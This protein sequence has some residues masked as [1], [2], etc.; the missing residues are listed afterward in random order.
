MYV[1]TISIVR[2]NNIPS[3]FFNIEPDFRWAYAVSSDRHLLERF[4][5][6]IQSFTDPSYL[7]WMPIEIIEWNNLNPNEIESNNLNSLFQID[8]F[9][10][11]G[12]VNGDRTDKY[13]IEEFLPHHWISSFDSEYPF[14]SYR[15]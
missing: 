3:A 12:I 13:T 4:K 6:K 7:P 1:L 10:V 2:G 8:L 5:E 14:N 11:C 15:I 9:Y